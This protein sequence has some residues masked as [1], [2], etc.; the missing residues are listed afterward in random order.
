[1]RKEY[2]N[3]VTGEVVTEVVLRARGAPMERLASIGIYP[4]EHPAPDYD[5]VTQKLELVPERNLVD[6]VFIQPYVAVELPLE[7]QERN[8]E[9]FAKQRADEA[10]AAA[11]QATQD[12]LSDFSTVEKMT[13]E[14]Q[15]LEVEAY[16]KNPSVATPTLDALAKERGIPREMQIQKAI[17]KVDAFTAMATVIVGTQQSYEDS[18]KTIAGDTAKSIQQRVDAL[19]DLG[20]VYNHA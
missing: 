16:K 17:V 9:S 15:R 2:Y 4:L 1:M 13:F 10:R 6:G 19:R 7:D 8:L 14:Q 12:Y 20:F 5:K 18:I 3:T 11:D